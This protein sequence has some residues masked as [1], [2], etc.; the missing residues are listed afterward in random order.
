MRGFHV[1]AASCGLDDAVS[2]IV[3]RYDTK[4]DCSDRIT[5][6]SKEQKIN[7]PVFSP[8]KLNIGI[9][10]ELSFEF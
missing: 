8:I 10:F 7:I 9:Y 3:A 2:K 5:S 4:N 6:Y 1:S